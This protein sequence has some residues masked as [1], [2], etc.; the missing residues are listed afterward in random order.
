MSG[1]FSVPKQLQLNF[2]EQG[3]I[4]L[5]LMSRGAPKLSHENFIILENLKY[6][7]R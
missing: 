5:G 2:G 7:F 4:F 6:N 3:A 1:Y